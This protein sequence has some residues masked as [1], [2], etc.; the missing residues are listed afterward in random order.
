MS[1]DHLLDDW[2]FPLFKLWENDDG[3]GLISEG[4][5]GNRCGFSCFAA[6]F[7]GGFRQTLATAILCNDVDALFLLFFSFIHRG[8]IDER[9]I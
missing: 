8:F 9:E 7:F 4:V 5:I 6:A 2:G 1:V 3:G